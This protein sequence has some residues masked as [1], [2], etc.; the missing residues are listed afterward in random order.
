MEW[1][2]MS[3]SKKWLVGSSHNGNS[4]TDFL[5]KAST[6]IGGGWELVGQEQ[7]LKVDVVIGR[8]GRI[9]G[10]YEEAWVKRTEKADGGAVYYGQMIHFQFFFKRPKK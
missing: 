1:E 6:L 7:I 8:Y 2:Y 9:D 10:Q 5:N 4:I 3:C